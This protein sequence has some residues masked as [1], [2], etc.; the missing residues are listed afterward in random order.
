[1]QLFLACG[2]I[3]E[4]FMGMLFSTIVCIGLLIFFG[5]RFFKGES[6]KEF[7]N[8][9]ALEKTFGIILYSV[10][11]LIILA[12]LWFILFFFFIYSN[13]FLV[14]KEFLKFV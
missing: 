3:F 5:I 8:S 6:Y 1:M 14:Y 4:P 7:K 12:F 2:S 11:G 13:R 9:K 10:L